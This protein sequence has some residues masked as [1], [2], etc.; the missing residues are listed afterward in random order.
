MKTLTFFI[1][2]I[3]T[4]HVS[5]RGQEVINLY[6]REAP[7]S[8][9]ILDSSERPILELYRPPLNE[10]TGTSILICPGGAYTFLAYQEEGISIARA[11]AAKGITAFV[12]KYR[13][14]KKSTMIEKSIGPLM[15]AQQALKVIRTNSKKWQLN[16]DRLGVI[17]F[18][19]GGH[20]ASTLGTHFKKDYIPNE[21]KCNLRPDFMI[22]I[23]PVI[24]MIDSITHTGSKISLLGMDPS[25]E[26]VENFS[27]ELQVTSATPPTYISHC[28]D[29]KTVDVSNSIVFYQALLK[30]G[31]DA[32]LHLFP[33]GDHGFIQRL[34]VNEWLTPILEFLNKE[35]FYRSEKR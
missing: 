30:K 12:L 35:G 31:I 29:D 28:G 21:D 26:M 20:L 25:K 7:N 32:E 17:G 4:L 9:T 27:N 13:L 22:L 33:K 1:G 34:Q 16:P 2:I 3:L 23:Y 10:S 19:A 14:P 6:N 24:S 18:S 15:D 8:R 11:F 5:V